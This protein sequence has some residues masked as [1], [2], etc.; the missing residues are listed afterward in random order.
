M[1]I[2]IRSSLKDYLFKSV[3]NAC[4]DYLRTERK[5][6]RKSVSID[7][8]ETVSAA[9]VDLGENPLGYVVSSETEQRIMQA[10]D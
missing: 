1:K 2:D 4:I 6:L 3:R 8:Q 9:L 7:E 10:I 5:R